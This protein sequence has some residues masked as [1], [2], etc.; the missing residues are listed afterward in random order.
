MGRLPVSAGLGEATYWL[1]WL[2]FLPAILGVSGASTGI[3]VPIQSMVYLICWLALPALV[4]RG[5]DPD[6]GVG[7]SRVFLQRILMGLGLAGYS[8]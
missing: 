5:G 3:L 7:S 1:V 6:R 8:A 2:L 4:G